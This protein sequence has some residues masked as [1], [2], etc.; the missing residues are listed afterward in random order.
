MMAKKISSI[1]PLITSATNKIIFLSPNPHKEHGI[2]DAEVCADR[3]ATIKNVTFAGFYLTSL[4]L[5]R[6]CDQL[7]PCPEYSF[8]R[9]SAVAE[10]STFFDFD[11][12]SFMQMRTDKQH[13]FTVSGE[14][15]WE[16]ADDVG[17]RGGVCNL[18]LAEHFIL[19]FARKLTSPPADW[20]DVMRC[21][22][23]RRG[24]EAAMTWRWLTRKACQMLCPPK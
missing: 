11:F 7:M 20:D 13:N 19:R 4:Q 1:N 23:E 22:M 10:F 12:K 9:C 21:A 14:E 6:G 8:L 5:I 16:L 17:R 18:P 3:R 15:M 24:I 2:Y